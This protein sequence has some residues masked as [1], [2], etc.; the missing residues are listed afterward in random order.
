MSQTI[1]RTVRRHAFAT[2][3]NELLRDKTITHRARGL[4]VMVLSHSAEWTTS[5]NWLVEQSLEGNDAIRATLTELEAAGYLQRT[6]ERNKAGKIVRHIQTWYD[7]KQPLPTSGFATCG[8][9]TCG[10][11]TCGKP[12]HTENNGEKNTNAE[13][14]QDG[15]LFALEAGSRLDLQAEQIYEAYPRKIAKPA[16]LKAIKSALKRSGL[17]FEE[18]RASVDFFA[19]ACKVAGTEAKYI[20]YPA[21]WFNN[22]RWT[23][24][25]PKDGPGN[26]W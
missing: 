21:T 17:A 26:K 19:N 8:K 7:E 24:N 23:D 22:D 9:T 5:Q 12:D 14:K 10:L 11:A 13:R 16:A 6:V 20:P 4:L 25:T 3:P 15:E 18:L 1:N 2:L